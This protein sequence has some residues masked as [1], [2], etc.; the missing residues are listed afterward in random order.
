MATRRIS[1]AL[2]RNC[3]MFL[4]ST[5][6]ENAGDRTTSKIPTELAHVDKNYTQK[7]VVTNGSF[8]TL[9]PNTD[10]SDEHITYGNVWP[11][12]S[13]YQIGDNSVI[14]EALEDNSEYHC[15]L[16]NYQTDRLVW[17]VNHLSTA[18]ETRSIPFKTLAFVFGQQYTVNGSPVQGKRVYACER[19]DIE[20]QCVEPCK[21]IEFTTITLEEYIDG[22]IQTTQTEQI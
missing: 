3:G 6:Y 16:P 13:R 7:H 21:I 12:R 5:L 19:N 1:R 4:T 8:R 9:F 15:V 10:E 2:L 11:A 20:V 22:L 14:V 18:G 17:Q